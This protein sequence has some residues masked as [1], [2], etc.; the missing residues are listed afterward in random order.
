MKPS[1]LLLN[2]FFAVIAMAAIPESE[3]PIKTSISM[4]ELDKQF[5]SNNDRE[6]FLKK[7][8]NKKVLLL[9]QLQNGSSSPT[10]LWQDAPTNQNNRQ[11]VEKL[12]KMAIRRHLDELAR[13]QQINTELS[14]QLEWMNHDVSAAANKAPVNKLVK[15]LAATNS[16]SEN[17]SDS[18]ITFH[19]NDVPVTTAS[20]SPNPIMQD[21]GT[22]KD[23]LTGLEWNSL[24]WWIAQKPASSIRACLK[25][26]IVFS[27][28]MQGRGHVVMIDHG[29]D[30]LTIYANMN[31]K[32]NHAKLGAD[33]RTG[34]IIGNSQESVYFE[35]RHKGK[36]VN[37]R[38][39]FGR[40]NLDI[41]GL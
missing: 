3:A 7:E 26:K 2:S 5:V 21:F 41:L 17:N 16:N 19:C 13:I 11:A 38:L 24:G 20:L 12:L 33:I 6:A 35:V 25:G 39:V 31:P 15:E 27:G 29:G 23:S 8:L 32:G 37:P 36:A 30:F 14:S 18:A 10:Y 1:L 22:R 40:Q 34:E 9:S 4:N 28:P